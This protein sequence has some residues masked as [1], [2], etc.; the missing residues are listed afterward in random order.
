[1]NNVLSVRSNVRCRFMRMIKK[2]HTHTSLSVCTQFVEK[3]KKNY[4][5]IESKFSKKWTMPKS[6]L[7]VKQESK[8]S[9]RHVGEPRK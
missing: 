1:M 8:I 4:V 6:V 7:R 2:G 9:A 3:K 5:E